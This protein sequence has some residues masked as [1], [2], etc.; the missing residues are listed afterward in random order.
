MKRNF[1][2]RWLLLGTLVLVMVVSTA[3]FAFSGFKGYFGGFH[4]KGLIKEKV[5]SRVD[6]A[7]QEL[8]LTPEQQTRYSAIRDKMGASI[9]ASA[10]RHARLKETIHTGINQP[11]PDIKALAGTLKKEI[12]TMPDSVTIQIDYMLEIYDIL[13]AQQQAQLVGMIKKRMEHHKPPRDCF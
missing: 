10:E 13:D 6:Y 3:G 12:R 7:M 8:K 4:G 2:K 9:D 5:L 11:Q 1:N